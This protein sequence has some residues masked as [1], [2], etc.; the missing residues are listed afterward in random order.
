MVNNKNKT[1]I[2]VCGLNDGGNVAALM[3]LQPD[4]IGF[5]FYEKSKRFFENE[6][7]KVQFIK[8]IKN[9]NKTGVFV[10]AGFEE[11]M[12]RVKRLN[13]QYVQLHGEET[14]DLCSKLQKEVKVIKAFSIKEHFDFKNTERYLL[15]CDY[16][17]FDC[18]TEAYGGSGKKFNWLQ[19]ENYHYAKKYFLSGGIQP[20]DAAAIKNLKLPGLFAID[21]NSG[22]EIAPGLKNI[23]EIKTFIHEIRN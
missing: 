8:N 5:I 2:K 6:T 13:L 12:Q 9:V 3:A 23:K 14:P 1:L 10:N 19:L 20:A 17:L 21:V 11:I 7:E 16:F 15:A 18:F 22:F 4:F